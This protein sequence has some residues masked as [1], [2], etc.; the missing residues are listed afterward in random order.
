MR[1]HHPHSLPRSPPR[2]RPRPSWPSKLAP[3]SRP[4]ATW[5]VA[6]WLP[7]HTRRIQGTNAQMQT[8]Q[9]DWNAGAGAGAGADGVTLCACVCVCAN[10][11]S[12]AHLQITRAGTVYVQTDT[13]KTHL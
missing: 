10:E 8:L 1:A 5:F 9:I 12:R 2:S 3:P 4:A 7:A 11:E 13:Y 6:C